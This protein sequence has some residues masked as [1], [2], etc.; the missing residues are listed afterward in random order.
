MNSSEA[1]LL[2]IGTPLI[3]FNNRM[4]QP[5][6]DASD[7]SNYLELNNSRYGL[8]E[9]ISPSKL[10]EL[11]FRH[12]KEGVEQ[13]QADFLKNHLNAEFKSMDTI[14]QTVKENK[15][16][17]LIVNEILPV[18][19][20][21]AMN[22]RIEGFLKEDRKEEKKKKRETEK[23]NEAVSPESLPAKV[24]KEVEALKSSLIKKIKDEYSQYQVQ[25]IAKSNEGNVEDKI[26]SL[27]L[28]TNRQERFGV[29]REDSLLCS[30]A[31][32]KN[33]MMID[34]KVYELVTVA[35]FISMFKQYISPQFYNRL[36]RF[37]S[38]REP[39]D[40]AELVEQAKDELEHKYHSRIVN[41]LMSSRLKINGNFYLPLYLEK[42]EKLCQ[43]YSKFLE[44]KTKIDAVEHNIYQT[45][46]MKKISDEKSRLEHIAG[47]RSYEENNA[48]FLKV[49]DRYYV[50]IKTPAYALK[51]PHF[52]S[53]DK[54]IEFAPAKVGVC[55][56]YD[57][58]CERFSIGDPVII[59]GY[60][61]PF[62]N[63]D[64]N[65]ITSICLGQWSGNEMS[66][67][68]TL[69]PEQAVLA[70]LSQGKKTL[71]M[72]YRTGNNPYNNLQRGNWNDWITKTEVDRKRL[73]C[74]N[75]FKE[76]DA[77]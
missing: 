18:L 57:S 45:E 6:I 73:V 50:Y 56:S 53:A 64:R 3:I 40:I 55:I 70:L 69:P 58:R 29:L 22:S 13:Y 17:S 47:K 9:I 27:M 15:V 10:E 7:D 74:L 14:K 42:A 54:Y 1:Y 77:R 19:T 24:R 76:G 72:G 4:I 2:E 52:T 33:I 63:Y 43:R 48:G 65:K 44:M 37:S 67:V 25:Q 20:E 62:V 8:E 23:K 66:R 41:K 39:R 35:D 31:L 26:A 5:K 60:R 68:R 38:K 11:Y 34:S 28:R 71:M 49:E 75:D 46:I 30:Y 12:N 51:S 32:N 21:D 59:D 36:Q 61:H 16:L